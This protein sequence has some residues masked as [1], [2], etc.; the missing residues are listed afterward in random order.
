M[1][2]ATPSLS[3]NRH[4]S[5]GDGNPPSPSKNKAVSTPSPTHE[6]DSSTRSLHRVLSTGRLGNRQ[7]YPTR[8]NSTTEAVTERDEEKGSVFHVTENSCVHSLS[9][10][11][12]SSFVLRIRIQTIR[13]CCSDEPWNAAFPPRSRDSTLPLSTSPSA[14]PLRSPTRRVAHARH[15]EQQPTLTPTLSN[16]SS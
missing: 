1:N 6:T 15:R 11:F 4:R 13:I 9:T 8:N 5:S 16:Q 12:L 3:P 2:R 10:C 7:P 14:P